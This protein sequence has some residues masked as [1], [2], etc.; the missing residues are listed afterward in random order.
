MSDYPDTIWAP[1]T[2]ANKSGVVYD[3][4]KSTIGFAE[5]FT[6]LEAE[7]LAI[8]DDLIGAGGA[9][10]L[11][12]AAASFKVNWLAEHTAAGAHTTDSIEEKTTGAGVKIQNN[13]IISSAVPLSGS[14]ADGF[15]DTTTLYLWDAP[16][17]ASG[18]YID[19]VGG[20][21]LTLSGDTTPSDDN[22]GVSRFNVFNGTDRFLESNNAALTGITGD[23]SA[24]ITFKRAA[25]T[26]GVT[27]ILM[28]ITDTSTGATDGWVIG[29][30]GG[31]LV[32]RLYNSGVSVDISRNVIGLDPNTYHT[33]AVSVDADGIHTLML[34]GVVVGC[35][36]AAT[37]SS[38]GTMLFNIATRANH[39]LKF[40]GSI[41]QAWIKKNEIATVDQLRQRYARSAK[42]FA[43]KDQANDVKITGKTGA[44]L[45]KSFPTTETHT[46]GEGDIADAELVSIVLPA[47]GLY[48][49]TS[50]IRFLGGGA[51]ADL[52]S[53]IKV[54]ASYA[55]GVIVGIAREMIGTANYHD[56]CNNFSKPFYAVAGQVVYLGASLS[57]SA[58]NRVIYGDSDYTD[59]TAL[60]VEMIGSQ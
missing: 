23:F 45:Y 38:A 2:K 27:E 24:G 39:S 33:A 20:K 57:A 19:S 5:D 32:L 28:G 41:G 56:M 36:G 46:S 50:K 55:A 44:V 30:F 7:L 21:D 54:G 59:T 60:C 37:V 9:G 13:T 51:P 1:R 16:T 11:K 31:V 29:I 25:I 26:S 10:G 14:T 18:N 52:Q 35:C 43:V 12:A 58:G 3:P 48:R 34:D 42:I 17:S 53:Y 6:Q 49:A 4:T 47:S 8:I 22:L 40:T 15:A